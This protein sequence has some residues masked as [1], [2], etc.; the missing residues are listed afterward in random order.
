MKVRGLVVR[1]GRVKK[2]SG[3]HKGEVKWLQLCWNP[4]KAALSLGETYRGFKYSMHT[5]LEWKHVLCQSTAVS[6]SG[7]WSWEVE[8][9]HHP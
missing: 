8:S 9:C 1:A 6:M 7:Q 3:S 2:K 4:V 5:K